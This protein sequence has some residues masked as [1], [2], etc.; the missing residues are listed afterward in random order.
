MASWE[1]K[2]VVVAGGTSG[3]GLCIA[4][5]FLEYGASVV[6][7]ARTQT[8]ID[9]AIANH[10]NGRMAGLQLDIEDGECTKGVAKQI[11]D[12]HG[13]IDAWV[14][15]V[16]QSTRTR[17]DNANEYRLLMDRNFF[18]TVNGTLAAVPYLEQT[19]GHLVNIGSLAAMTAWPFLGPYVTAKHAVAGF[20]RQM[21]LEG[22]PGIHFL[23]VCPGPIR[24]DDAKTRYANAFD[25]VPEDA[26]TPGAHAPLR[27]IDPNWLSR[28]IV[29][30]CET[31]KLEII[32]PWHAKFLFAIANTS[33]WLGDQ[34]LRRLSK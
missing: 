8:G 23:L 31:R 1:K 30:A 34:L 14:N 28:K 6:V 3:L 11:A 25:D 12:A 4:K 18:T 9:A 10:A 26:L 15:A 16:G 32:V 2:V 22:P 21:R 20:T 17:F 13:R 24:R 29:R 33:P 19:R 27:G 7:L 5:S